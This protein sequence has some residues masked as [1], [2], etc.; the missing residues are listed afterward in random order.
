MS[1]NWN[2]TSTNNPA[3]DTGTNQPTPQTPG[4]NDPWYDPQQQQQTGTAPGALDGFQQ[5]PQQPPNYTDGTNWGN[6]F[7]TPQN[8]GQANIW[9]GMPPS[10]GNIG[11]GNGGFSNFQNP[12]FG[13][14]PTP[15]SS[16]NGTNLPYT[17]GV[18]TTGSISALPQPTNSASAGG[19]NS[20]SLAQ[21]TNYANTQEGQ[22]QRL[23]E[24]PNGPYANRKPGDYGPIGS[25]DYVLNPQNQQQ[26]V[27]RYN[28]FQ[29]NPTAFTSGYTQPR[30]LT[31]QQY[32][33]SKPGSVP[34]TAFANNL[35]ADTN[36][37][38][39][40]KELTGTLTPDQLAQTQKMYGWQDAVAGLNGDV[41]K[42]YQAA[43][44]MAR[45]NPGF[46]FEV[47]KVGQPDGSVAYS[48]QK[49]SQTPQ[50]AAPVANTGGGGGGSSA[51]STAPRYT[52]TPQRTA[53]SLPAPQGRTTIQPGTPLDTR[54][55]GGS[56]NMQHPVEGQIINY[57]GQNVQF[58]QG[59]WMPLS[60]TGG[61]QRHASPV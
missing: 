41:N 12:T 21:P 25:P 56:V 15:A 61:D 24:D 51:R 59:R 33:Y 45:A 50:A 8:S 6:V 2:S 30:D 14:S 37:K 40:F 46:D 57:N 32:D 43:D 20:N 48:L 44:V 22:I 19:S 28:W 4:Y 52:P 17:S 1:F 49:R 29:Q 60:Y 27:E 34:Y 10:Y 7:G 5:T 31:A 13:S 42:A 58:R 55:T 36:A 54:M 18:H 39:G 35:Y 3:F 11:S 53:A 16:G 23:L 38:Q 47:V 9:Q 26:W